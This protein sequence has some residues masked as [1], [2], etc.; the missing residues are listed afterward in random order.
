MKFIPTDQAKGVWG[1]E[2]FPD[3]IYK[4]NLEWNQKRTHPHL[5][6]AG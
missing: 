6:D 5:D 4:R 3:T 1:K 2:K